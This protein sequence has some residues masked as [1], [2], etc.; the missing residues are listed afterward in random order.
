MGNQQEKELEVK[1]KLKT[2]LN[3]QRKNFKKY[4]DLLEQEKIDIEKREGI[5]LSLHIK[6]DRALLKEIQKLYDVI[7]SFLDFYISNYP[8]ES[9]KEISNWDR[10]VEE[11]I[12]KSG[13][14]LDQN[15]SLLKEKIEQ[16]RED[17]IG[18]RKFR[19]KSTPFQSSVTPSFI[20]ISS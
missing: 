12:K 7:D 19:V 11:F 13:D 5:N 20:D 10:E 18:F 4:L 14:L 6:A 3:I 9:E 17:I 2:Y 15:R 8:V 16:I 1:E